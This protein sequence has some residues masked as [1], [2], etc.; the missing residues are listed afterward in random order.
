MKTTIDWLKFRTHSNP[1]KIIDSM[2][3]AFG[4]C[5][6]LI[7]LSPLEKGRDGWEKRQ[8]IM[9]VDIRLGAIDYGGQ[10]Q[11]DWVRVDMSGT[12][13]EW[14]QDLEKVSSL[15]SVLDGFELKRVDIALTTFKGEITDSMIAQAHADGLFSGLGRPP[16]M[17]SILSSDERAGKT[18]YIGSREKSDKFLRCYEKGFEMIK[19]VPEW[20][21]RGTTELNGNKVDEIY[22]VELELKAEN[23][24]IP[25]EVLVK[26]DEYFAGAYP[27]LALMLPGVQHLKITK[28]PDEKPLSDLAAKLAHCKSAYGSTIFTAMEFY[29][30]DADKVLKMIIGSD[31]SRK[32]VDSGV[33]TL[34]S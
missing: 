25:T 22:R 17:R 2:L 27:F 20:L 6:D 30:G 21:K 19:N 3:P 32:L 8:E 15:G 29:K 11:R 9:L 24:E 1:F 23:K 18:R 33:L 14:I 34:S 4:T 5:G 26:R 31:H 16:A 28:L 13:C 10:S 7:T 12:G